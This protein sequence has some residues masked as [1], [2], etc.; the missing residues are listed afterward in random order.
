MG[1]AGKDKYDIKLVEPDVSPLQVQGPKSKN[2][3]VDLFGSWINDLKYYWC[4]QIEID[5][6][7]VVVSRTSWSGEIGY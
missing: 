2:L 3:M 7:P 6:I 1:V 4:K 5:G